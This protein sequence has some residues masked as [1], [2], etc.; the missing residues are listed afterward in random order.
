MEHGKGAEVAPESADNEVF[1]LDGVAV[2]VEAES[3]VRKTQEVSITVDS[4]TRNSAAALTTP[5]GGDPS[6][7]DTSG[8]SSVSRTIS[9]LSVLTPGNPLDNDLDMFKGTATAKPK[10]SRHSSGVLEFSSHNNDKPVLIV[11][12]TCNLLVGVVLS[13]IASAKLDHHEHHV[14]TDVVSVVTMTLLSFIMIGVGC[15]FVI[16]KSNL[17]QYGKDYMVAMTAAGFP[18]LFVGAWFI[19][20]LPGDMWWGEA[21]FTARFAAP[22]SAGILFTMLQAAGLQNTWLFRKA[23]VLAIFDDLDTILFMLPLKVIV[24]GFHWEIIFD[25][26]LLSLPLVAAWRYMHAIPLPGEWPYKLMYAAIIVSFCKGLH[27]MSKYHL[28]M[29]PIHLEVLLPAFVLGCIMTH[30][31]ESPMEKRVG[32]LV[33]AIFMFCVGLSTPPLQLHGAQSVLSAD[34]A[35]HIVAITVLMIVGKMFPLFCYRDEADWQT[36]FALSLGMC[37]RGEVGAGII[38]ISIEAGISGPA[39]QLAVVCL[40]INLVLSGA[41]VT[42]TRKLARASEFRIAREREARHLAKLKAIE[43]RE[44]R[45]K[46]KAEKRELKKQVR[47]LKN[48]LA[49]E[50]LEKQQKEPSG[51]V[52][53]PTRGEMHK[54]MA[55]N[56]EKFYSA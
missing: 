22:T 56:A 11:I 36:R 31:H 14:Y 15:E 16:D 50:R 53:S 24:S 38:V 25:I 34:M 3:P 1:C 33:S 40:V 44:R 4:P 2:T 43:R 27:H 20:M 54:I 12:F 48:Q 28:E 5:A 30:S 13:Q 29:E 52:H 17:G 21:L 9:S 46:E 42:W 6:D 32:T 37:P 26:L 47:E 39:V 7:S 8:T 55:G 45:K 41:F 35:W 23:R 10:F 19:W 18:W 51:E 49:A